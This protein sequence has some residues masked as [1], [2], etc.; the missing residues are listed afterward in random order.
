MTSLYDMLYEIDNSFDGIHLDKIEGYSIVGEIR[1][2][3]DEHPIQYR[4]LTNV[5][6]G[7]DDP[8]EGLGWTP[9]EAVRNLLKSLNGKG[10]K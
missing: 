9:T 5:R 8:F 7:E 10:A 4:A 3:A 6:P 1:S 2:G